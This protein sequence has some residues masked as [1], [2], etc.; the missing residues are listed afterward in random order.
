MY[1]LG[2]NLQQV[3]ALQNSEERNML[4]FIGFKSVCNFYSHVHEVTQIYFTEFNFMYGKKIT[5]KFLI[6]SFDLQVINI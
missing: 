1:S 2:L 6:F 3:T 4:K 5:S